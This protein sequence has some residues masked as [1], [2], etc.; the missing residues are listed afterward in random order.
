MRAKG[1]LLAAAPLGLAVGYAWSAIPA[2]TAKL[3]SNAPARAGQ[4]AEDIEHSVYYAR[5]ADAW[6]AGKAPIF[7][8]QPGYREA[9]DGDSDGI[10]CEPYR[11]Y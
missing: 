3:A 2:A 11:G 10:A 6:A 8:G 4:T 7:R 9:L 1:I 5:C